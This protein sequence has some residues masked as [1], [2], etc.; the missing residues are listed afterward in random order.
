MSDPFLSSDQYAESAHQLYLEGL[1]EQ[2]VEILKEALERY[3]NSTELY[4]GLAYAQLALEEYGWARAGF[5]TAL[6]LDPDQE[7][8]LAGLGETLLKLGERSQ[9]LQYFD[10]VLALGHREDL[11]LM[12]QIGRALFREGMLRHARGFFEV[13][14]EHHPDS[15]EAAACMGYAT[16]R[17]GDEETALYWLRRALDIEETHMEARIYLGNL[18]YDRGEYEAS[19]FHF[20]RTDPTEHFDELA[21]WRAV[22]LKKSVYRLSKTDPELIPWRERL[23][24]LM[25]EQDEVDRLLAEIA[26]TQPGGSVRDPH[27]IEL[28][29]T[30]LQELQ[31][32]QRRGVADVH[33][34]KTAS[35]VTYA[36]TWEEIVF[37]MKMDDHDGVHASLAEFMERVALRSRRETGAVIPVT[38]AESF[39]QGVAA[40]G[41]IQILR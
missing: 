39:V 36:G 32:M 34:V 22:E 29:G 10:R 5:E 11:D 30:L 27:Q 9:A 16:H 41:L 15:A 37:Q 2:A 25:A 14:V 13:A 21:L 4:L 40:A 6:G 20:E 26:S 19:L 28:F 7:E 17:L 33:R 12:L 38:D 23:V 3:P 1:Y 18:L 8:V 35:G 31:G 24:E